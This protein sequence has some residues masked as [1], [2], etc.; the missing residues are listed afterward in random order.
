MNQKY[1]EY[2]KKAAREIAVPTVGSFTKQHIGWIAGHLPS[3]DRKPMVPNEFNIL[4]NE[5]R[6]VMITSLLDD[7]KGDV[8]IPSI[9]DYNKWTEAWLDVYQ[10]C[11]LTLYNN[12]K[13][14]LN[15]NYI[16]KRYNEIICPSGKLYYLPQDTTSVEYIA[17]LENI[18]VN[19]LIS[20]KKKMGSV[21][22]NVER[23]AARAQNIKSDVKVSVVKTPI[24]FDKTEVTVGMT[25][26]F[27]KRFRVQKTE[28]VKA[29]EVPIP[30][31]TNN[32][33]EVNTTNQVNN[34]EFELE[35][36]KNEPSV[37]EN[38]E[39]YGELKGLKIPDH[40]KLEKDDIEKLIEENSPFVLV[41]CADLSKE[42]N[43][44]CYNA[45]KCLEAG[46]TIGAYINGKAKDSDSALK[47]S[48]KILELLR[49]YQI[50]G[51]VIYEINNDY[52]HSHDSEEDI[53]NIINAYNGVASILTEQGYPV[54]V[55]VEND[56]AILLE[57]H[58][59]RKNIPVVFPMVYRIVPHELKEIPK[60]V[61]T[62]L[63]DP[64]YVNDIIRIINPDFKIEK[65]KQAA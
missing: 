65:H 58:I 38:T 5:G 63:M 53:D 12:F 20:L 26:D 11:E 60:N 1:E 9:D 8:P 57:R 61:S 31:R 28:P 27:A 32:I 45:E 35:S 55:A 17:V 50:K 18:V 7:N 4:K 64:Q 29:P 36:Q 33:P 25:E 6:K 19:T 52:M 49:D 42:R 62:I 39:L 48:K 15:K 16:S 22:M 30:A 3:K 59:E 56:N 21:G 2:I 10:R 34:Q 40:D 46:L 41:T 47:D 14:L 23:A 51:P 13:E 24:K 43:L 54:L 37:F 44:F